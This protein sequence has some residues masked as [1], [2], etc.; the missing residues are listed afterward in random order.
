MSISNIIEGFSKHLLNEFG[1]AEAPEFA[2]GRLNICN[3]CDKRVPNPFNDEEKEKKWC[4]GCGC[5]IP[6]KVLVKNEKCPKELWQ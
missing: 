4:G 5:F 6:A 1:L 3:G 2:K